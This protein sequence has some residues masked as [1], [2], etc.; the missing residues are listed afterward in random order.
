MRMILTAVELLSLLEFGKASAET[1][2]TADVISRL[3]DQ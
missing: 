1:M 2:A 3:V